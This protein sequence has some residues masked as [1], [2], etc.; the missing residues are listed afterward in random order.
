MVVRESLV[1]RLSA[2]SWSLVF[3]VSANQRMYTSLD[4][5]KEKS[6]C[7]HEKIGSELESH[8]CLND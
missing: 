4:L 8:R 7:E 3:I 1:G 2:V 5:H 6:L